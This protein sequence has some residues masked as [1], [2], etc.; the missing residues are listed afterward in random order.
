M[1]I[2]VEYSFRCDILLEV[3]QHRLFI[4]YEA[5]KLK[6]SSVSLH[7]PKALISDSQ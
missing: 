7:A 6:G 2:I 3:K 4:L 5:F 1:N